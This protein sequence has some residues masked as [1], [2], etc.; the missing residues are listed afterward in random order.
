MVFNPAYEWT[1]DDDAATRP[2]GPFSFKHMMLSGLGL[3]WGY[4]GPDNRV[5]LL[6]GTR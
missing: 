4:Y 5:F 1:L 6:F 2:E 3:V